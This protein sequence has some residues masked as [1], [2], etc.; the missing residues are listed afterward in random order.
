M[1]ELVERI[2]TAERRPGTEVV[3]RLGAAASV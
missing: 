3:V 2:D 1:P